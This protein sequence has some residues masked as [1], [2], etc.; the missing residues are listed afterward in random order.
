MN[1]KDVGLLALRVTVGGLMAGHGAQK[2]FGAFGGHGLEGTGQFMESLGLEPAKKWAALAG[3]AEFGGGVLTMLGLFHP[4][5]PIGVASAM[6]M[7]TGT[8]HAGKPIWGTEGGAELPVTNIAAASALA[9]AGPGRLSLDR[10]LGI[11]MPWPVAMFMAGSA[12]ASVYYGLQQANTTPAGEQDQ[13]IELSPT[14]EPQTAEEPVREFTEA[15]RDN[16]YQTADA[17]G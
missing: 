4:L 17:P 9:L 6:A 16:L 2:L 1:T 5:G 7:A 8:A 14:L 10:A 13:Q 3:L 11:R 15:T 12:A